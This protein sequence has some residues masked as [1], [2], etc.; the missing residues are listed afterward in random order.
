MQYQLSPRI[1]PG[2]KIASYDWWLRLS[3]W[4][5]WLA[6]SMNASSVLRLLPGRRGH[7]DPWHDIALVNPLR[8]RQCSR[9]ARTPYT[10]AML[11]PSCRFGGARLCQHCKQYNWVAV[12]VNA[13][14]IT[15]LFTIGRCRVAVPH[16]TNN[17]TYHHTTYN[18]AWCD[19]CCIRNW[20]WN[21]RRIFTGPI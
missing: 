8:N 11:N 19:D 4:I 1:P 21:L 14:I 10:S 5:K 7:C 18:D 2:G 3:S 12:D 16:L 6:Q 13:V 15:L 20:F 9:S 17:D